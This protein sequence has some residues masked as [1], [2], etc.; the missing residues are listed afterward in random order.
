MPES[1]AKNQSAFQRRRKR[2]VRI[3]LLTLLAVAAILAIALFGRF[4]TRRKANPDFRFID[5]FRTETTSSGLPTL[6][7]LPSVSV[8]P[9]S[10]SEAGSTAVPSSKATEA[11]STPEHTTTEAVTEPAV[12]EAPVTQPPVTE[13]PATEEPTAEEPSSEEPAAT[14]GEEPTDEEP[15]GE[16]P[17]GEEPAEESSEEP[18]TEEP[19]E[20]RIV[21]NDPSDIMYHLSRSGMSEE[22]IADCRQLVAVKSDAPNCML[23]FFEQ[24]DNGWQLTEAVPATAGV[25]GRGGVTAPENKHEGDN[26]TPTGY[27]R[28]GPCYG[29][30]KDSITAMEYHQILEGDFWVDDSNSKYYNRFFS[31]DMPREERDFN[32]A[33]S[34]HDMLN[35]YALMVLIQYNYE[36]PVPYAGSAIFLHLQDNYKDT[37][38]CISTNDA[39]MFAIFLW[40]RPEA[41]PHILIY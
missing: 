25:M 31:H 6:P 11:P 20:P 9:E 19:T 16:E 22:D 27:Y 29:A 10:G 18:V 3:I 28:L 21:Y 2:N 33:E 34:L 39:T 37:S 17:S 4:L 36:D 41:D 30:D 32:G 1:R 24:G 5:L 15:T 38:G 12:T 14:T 23:Y 35:Y 13:E 7:T 26:C 8:P 40:L